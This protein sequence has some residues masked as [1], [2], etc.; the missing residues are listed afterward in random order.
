MEIIKISTDSQ[1]QMVEVTAEVRAVI[2]KLGV[3]DGAVL[4]Y[5]PHT[6]AGVLINECYDPDVNSDILNALEEI[7]PKINYRHAEGNSPAHVKAMLVGESVMV[8][9]VKGEMAI[10]Q[11]QGIVFAEFDGPRSRTIRVQKI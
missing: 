5:C 11:W 6:T 1:T 2:R 7:E 3:K 9:V 8:P 10:G 4:V